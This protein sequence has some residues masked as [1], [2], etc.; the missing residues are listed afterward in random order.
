MNHG[1]DDRL[2]A[3]KFDKAYKAI[4][5]FAAGKKGPLVPQRLQ[6]LRRHLRA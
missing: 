6:A 5:G 4:I 3:G 2:D 1:L